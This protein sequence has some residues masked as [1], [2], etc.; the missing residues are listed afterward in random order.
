MVLSL[1]LTRWRIR[2]TETGS[3]LENEFGV[4]ALTPLTSKFKV[5]GH[6]VFIKSS[7]PVRNAQT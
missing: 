2:N 3:G 4:T 1:K 7:I 6:T 5:H